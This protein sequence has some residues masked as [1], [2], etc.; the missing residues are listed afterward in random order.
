M[1]IQ[2]T[3][4]KY[5][6]TEK[7]DYIKIIPK[8]K[9]SVIIEYTLNNKPYRFISKLKRGPSDIAAVK[10]NEIDITEEILPYLG[11]NEDMHNIRYTPNVFGYDSMEFYMIDGSTLKFETDQEINFSS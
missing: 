1:Y 10:Y 11:P 3:Y 7:N 6:K 5:F 9:Y 8:T 2:I 4:K